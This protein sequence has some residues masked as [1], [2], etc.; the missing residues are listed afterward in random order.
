MLTFGP[1][2]NLHVHNGSSLK[3]F[4]KQIGC[5]NDDFCILTQL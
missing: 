1:P 4:S 2:C 5:F 3:Q